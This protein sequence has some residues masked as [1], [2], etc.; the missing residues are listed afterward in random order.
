MGCNVAFTATVKFD[1]Q[2]G[3]IVAP[4]T[5]AI[6]STL[7]EPKT[8]TKKGETFGGWSKDILGLTRWDFEEDT[9]FVNTT[10]YAMWGTYYT[11]TF[12]SNGGTKVDKQSVIRGGHVKSVSNPTKSGWKFDGWYID[13]TNEKWN[14]SVSSV[15]E[16][17]ILE[18]RW[19]S[20]K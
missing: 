10:L 12:N 11:V 13:T 1:S 7:I 5:V 16:D 18:A 17:V 8:P 2:G 15:T 14:F 19:K 20:T 3:S 6:G 4:Q 9:V